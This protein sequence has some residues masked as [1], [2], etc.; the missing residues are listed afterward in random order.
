MRQDWDG[1]VSADFDTH[2]GLQLLTVINMVRWYTTKGQEV[3]DVRG[4]ATTRPDA[5]NGAVHGQPVQAFTEFAK[6]ITKSMSTYGMS[7][8]R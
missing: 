3:G 2:D 4:N 7:G 5:T 6:S 8:R 1:M